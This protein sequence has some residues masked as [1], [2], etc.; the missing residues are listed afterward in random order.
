M[1]CFN[2]LIDDLIRQCQENGT[3]RAECAIIQTLNDRAFENA[4]M[5]GAKECT[6]AE[7]RDRYKA[8]VNAMAQD[9]LACGEAFAKDNDLCVK[10]YARIMDAKKQAPMRPSQKPDT[11]PVTQKEMKEKLGEMTAFVMMNG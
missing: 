2:A 9:L 5:C 6:V 1:S 10:M 4:L 3:S 8:E 11:T 7:F